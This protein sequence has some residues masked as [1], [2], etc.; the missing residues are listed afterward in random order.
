MKVIPT[1]AKTLQIGDKE[2]ELFYFIEGN[3]ML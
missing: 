2:V 1:L 3:L